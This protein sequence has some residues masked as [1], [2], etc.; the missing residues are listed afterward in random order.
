[1]KEKHLIVVFLLTFAAVGLM[2][3]SH[4]AFA[5]TAESK[6]SPPI[7]QKIAPNSYYYNYNIQEVQKEPQG[8]GEL[9][10][11][12]QYD[13]VEIKGE[14]TRRK[15]LNAI[16]SVESSTDTAIITAVAQER[17]TAKD[18]I[19]DIAA[20]SY[21]QIDTYVDNTFSNL[22][23]AQKTALKRLY[24]TVLAMLRQADLND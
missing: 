18:K 4:I 7:I 13:Y 12:Y 1:M 2:L 3:Y 5:Q 16:K 8:G 23:A 10:T 11:F 14:P 9:E 24:K 21:A 19:K 17:K 6:I 15:V 22:S 20:M